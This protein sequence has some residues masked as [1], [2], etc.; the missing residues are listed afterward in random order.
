MS[1]SF[2]PFILPDVDHPWLVTACWDGR[3]RR[4]RFWCRSK[5]EAFIWCGWC[6]SHE[7]N[8]QPEIV[9]SKSWFGGEDAD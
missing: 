9:F 7:P 4:V 1:A 2:L 3:S 6:L 8:T 5:E